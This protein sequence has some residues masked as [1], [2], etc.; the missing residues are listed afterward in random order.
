MSESR[1]GTVSW[2][3][4]T[5]WSPRRETPLRAF[6]RTETGSAAVLL[7]ATLAALA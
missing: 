7:C 2:S 6:L 1:T 4:S 5:A 3:G